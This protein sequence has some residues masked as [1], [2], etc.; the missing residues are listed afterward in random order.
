MSSTDVEP[1]TLARQRI[2]NTNKTLMA[3]IGLG[4]A[5]ALDCVSRKDFFKV[6]FSPSALTDF[7]SAEPD[8]EKQKEEP[9]AVS[10]SLFEGTNREELW[11]P[12]Q[13]SW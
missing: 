10:I 7:L 8:R 2:R 3:I 9:L 12:S 6:V 13:K 11:L 4:P 1:S 5:I